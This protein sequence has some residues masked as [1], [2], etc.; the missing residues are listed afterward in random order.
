MERR[1][2]S[3]AVRARVGW[4]VGPPA[5]LHRDAQDHRPALRTWPAVVSCQNG[6]RVVLNAKRWLLG[7][8]SYRSD[9]TNYRRY[10]VNHEFGHALGK[11]HVD[12]PGAREAGTGH[13]AADQG[14]RGL[15]EEP[16]AAGH[17]RLSHPEPSAQ[18]ADLRLVPLPVAVARLM[19]AGMLHAENCASRLSN[20]HPGIRVSA[21]RQH[22][23]HRDVVR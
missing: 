17:R 7:A 11:R 8:E 9:L 22:R 4:R 12:C 19:L 10:L 3:L 23:C 2:P 1:H 16:M 15:P 18:V 5:C 6:T 13:D 20:S 21:A 14:T